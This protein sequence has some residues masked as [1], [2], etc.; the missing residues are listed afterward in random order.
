MTFASRYYACEVGFAFVERNTRAHP[1][2]ASHIGPE[3]NEVVSRMSKWV[4]SLE[5][6]HLSAV[7]LI[8]YRFT[9][10]NRFQNA[11]EKHRM[12]RTIRLEDAG[13]K[14]RHGVLAFN[15]MHHA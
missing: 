12:Y 10:N 9:H 11:D 7:R 1:A 5:P 4:E 6:A 3:V 14:V 15:H 2:L 13:V 8:D